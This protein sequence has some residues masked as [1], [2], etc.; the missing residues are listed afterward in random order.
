MTSTMQIILQNASCLWENVYKSILL[1][2]ETFNRNV[3]RYNKTINIIYLFIYIINMF[4][5]DEKEV[6]LLY[7]IT[8]SFQKIEINLG[9]K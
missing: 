1:K 8:E 4:S 7:V 2:H 5:T 9:L 3:Q 6:L